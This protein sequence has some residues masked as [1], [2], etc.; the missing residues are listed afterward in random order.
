M[1]SQSSTHAHYTHKMN[2][3]SIA[4]D[5]KCHV[6]LFLD[7]HDMLIGHRLSRIWN[8]LPLSFCYKPKRA[9][10][11]PFNFYAA[12]NKFGRLDVD[13]Y[14]LDYIRTLDVWDYDDMKPSKASLLC[15]RSYDRYYQ[16]HR[17]KTVI[18]NNGWHSD[19]MRFDK[20]FDIL[21]CP[22][23]SIEILKINMHKDLISNFMRN[24]RLLPKKIKEIYLTSNPYDWRP[25]HLYITYITQEMRVFDVRCCVIRINNKNPN[26]KPRADSDIIESLKQFENLLSLRTYHATY[27][28]TNNKEPFIMTLKTKNMKSK[29]TRMRR[30]GIY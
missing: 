29:E 25:M 26:I 1:Y 21:L 23:I 7:L 30:M 6:L 12:T 27:E 24:L 19:R 15:E 16:F 2:V 20:G 4:R 28:R 18:I 17:I 5:I 9:S 10:Q 22:F 8:L 14:N 11:I 3:N 13:K